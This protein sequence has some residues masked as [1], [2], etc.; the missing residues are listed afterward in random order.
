[1]RASPS[2]GAD[3][4]AQARPGAKPRTRERK[5]SFK[6]VANTAAVVNPLLTLPK[7][8]GHGSPGRTAASAV[9]EGGLFGRQA[10]PTR[11]MQDTERRLLFPR[12]REV[13]GK[14][15]R[16]ERGEEGATRKRKA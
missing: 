8:H 4:D 12:G 16:E 1:M 2:P 15:G 14:R 6:N 5:T 9:A 13:S 10:S 7:S 3:S 11:G